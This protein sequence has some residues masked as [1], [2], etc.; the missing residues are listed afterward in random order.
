MRN[1]VHSKSSTTQSLKVD[2][3][4][5]W[6]YKGETPAPTPSTSATQVD[7]RQGRCSPSPRL[8]VAHLHLPR[9]H[10]QIPPPAPIQ[11]HPPTRRHPPI[12]LLQASLTHP[13][14]PTHLSRAVLL[15]HLH[16]P[17]PS[18]LSPSPMYSQA[19]PSTPGSG[20]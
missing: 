6:V 3:V 4:P 18:A 5:Q 12:R 2:R 14:P 11:R 20:V 9:Y 13:H 19:R 7:C 8:Y 17:L 10:L 16:L 15:I 1:K